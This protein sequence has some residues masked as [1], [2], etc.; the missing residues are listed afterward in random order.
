MPAP[1]TAV[2]P[3]AVHSSA[4]MSTMPLPLHSF[5]PAQVLPL[6][7]AH[8]PLPLHSLTPVQWTLAIFSPSPPV[9]ACSVVEVGVVEPALL[10]LPPQAA[11]NSEPAAIAI[12]VPCF[13]LNMS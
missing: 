9:A 5:L 8:P 11:A 4:V 2:P 6:G 10:D 13:R 1:A 12:I 7:I 3:L